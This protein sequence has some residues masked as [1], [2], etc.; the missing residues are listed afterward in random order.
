MA[1]A[2]TGRDYPPIFQQLQDVQRCT[3]QCVQEL[4]AIKSPQCEYDEALSTV[5]ARLDEAWQSLYSS[6]NDSERSDLQKKIVEYGRELERLKVTFEAGLEDA[7][8]SYRSRIEVASA[9]YH[10]DLIAA[11]GPALV[12]R[13]LQKLLASAK[14]DTESAKRKRRRVTRYPSRPRKQRRTAAEAPNSEKG[15]TASHRQEQRSRSSPAP[16]IRDQ[17]TSEGQQKNQVKVPTPGE[18]YLTPWGSSSARSAV[19][20]LPTNNLRDVG[21]P[22]TLDALGLTKHVPECYEYSRRQKTFRWRKEYEDG[23]QLAHQRQ[24]PVMYFDGLDFPRKSAVGWVAVEDLWSFDANDTKACKLIEHAWQVR[25]YLSERE[26]PH[27]K[28]V[29][30]HEEVAERAT[31]DRT[32]PLSA[33]IGQQRTDPSTGEYGA[34]QQLP[35]SPILCTPDQDNGLADPH[36]ERHS[37]PDA[38]WSADLRM[39]PQNEEHDLVPTDLVLAAQPTER[40]AET[41]AN[42]QTQ[43]SERSEQTRPTDCDV[44]Q[45]VVDVPVNGSTNGEDL[46]ARTSIAEA[47]K[48]INAAHGCDGLPG[49]ASKN[50]QSDARSGT[51]ISGKQK[52]AADVASAPSPDGTTC[53]G[54][55]RSQQAQGIGRGVEESEV[56][57]VANNPR[58][59][60]LQSDHLARISM[61]PPY[62][63]ILG[64]RMSAPASTSEQ[65]FRSLSR[66]R[67]QSIPTGRPIGDED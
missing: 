36:N 24:Y 14:G 16:L 19:L 18:V 62:S 64:E 67:G 1:V 57:K 21:I 52:S 55:L 34:N 47:D 51:P 43:Q 2:M 30:T 44:V 23:G 27:A 42:D 17:V 22:Y 15:D 20:L 56:T 46:D 53:S 28:C 10:Q 61:N 66:G 7:E 38:A 39:Q 4:D 9:E 8:A 3:A 58:S 26:E 13:T 11:L 31:V 5:N 41:E 35:C 33:A 29:L 32:L 40:L 48:D 63:A 25:K 49:S 54:A 65:S 12:Q 6:Q 37:I 59:E 45:H 60:E 50:E